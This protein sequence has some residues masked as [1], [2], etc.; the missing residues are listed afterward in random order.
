MV[1][2]SVGYEVRITFDDMP[3]VESVRATVHVQLDTVPQVADLHE[4]EKTDIPLNYLIRSSENAPIMIA[5]LECRYSIQAL[6]WASQ[7]P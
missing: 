6:V 7:M 4:G 3:R 2:M 1:R 5:L